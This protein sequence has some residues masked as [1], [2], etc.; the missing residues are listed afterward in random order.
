[1]EENP[2]AL[3][4]IK[5]Q[6]QEVL[7]SRPY[8][9]LK[10]ALDVVGALILIVLLTPVFLA[11][12]LLVLLDVGR[13]VVFWQRR[14]GL[15]GRP[16]KLYKF[17]SMA[18][19]H[20]GQGRRIPED[21]RVSAIGRALRRTRLDELP[22]LFHILVGQMSFIGPRPLL[23]VDQPVGHEARLLVRPGLTGWAQVKGGRHLT[24]L[25]KA[26]LDVWYV[27]HASPAV[28]LEILLRTVLI[29]LFGEQENVEAV[30]WAWEDMKN[31]RLRAAGQQ[32]A[33]YL[34]MV[35]KGSGRHAA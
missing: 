24:P 18:A 8:W 31:P 6:E 3:L 32:A 5:A 29:V 35:K 12:A 26:A 2:A 9:R 17:R 22:Q 27:R 23:P 15:G 28:D 13:P 25:D 34:A 11:V 30:R 1:L 19:A 4:T 21:Q 16:F 20:D 7:K 10:R 14:P 33:P